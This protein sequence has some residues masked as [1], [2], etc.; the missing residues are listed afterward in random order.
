MIYSAALKTKG[1]AGPS[2]MDA[3]L[4]RR[5]LCSKNF[6]TEGKL[7]KEEIATMARNML[8]TSYHLSQPER[9]TAS[10]L[11]PLNKRPWSLSNWNW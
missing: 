8:T 10:R 3:D 1:S 7:L 4:Y 9:Y 6:N 2:G 11:I 5:I